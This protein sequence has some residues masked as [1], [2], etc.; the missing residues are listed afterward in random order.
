MIIK[1]IQIIISNFQNT[2]HDC[3][4]RKSF[5]NQITGDSSSMALLQ[6]TPGLASLGSQ[7]W[8]GARHSV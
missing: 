5:S 2:N 6:Q 7:M 8:Q 3:D 1:L 4:Y